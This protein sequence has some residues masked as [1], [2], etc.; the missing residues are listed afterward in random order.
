MVCFS[1]AVRIAHEK[2][3]FARGYVNVAVGTNGDAHRGEEAVG[4]EGLFPRATV[5]IDFDR[6]DAVGGV[7]GVTGGWKVGV[8]FDD[9]DAT[10]VVDADA[11]GGHD[12]GLFEDQIE[13][14]SGVEKARGG[15]RTEG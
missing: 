3:L 15:R 1:I 7:A 14:E 10:E 9:P 8:A 13:L 11:C 12:A 6:P 4:E 5:S 2:N